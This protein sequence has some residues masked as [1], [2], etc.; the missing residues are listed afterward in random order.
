MFFPV[1]LQGELKE[2]GLL[3]ADQMKVWSIEALNYN[4]ALEGLYKYKG[5]GMYS[6]E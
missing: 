5:W 1:R 6:E 3:P 2:L 4:L